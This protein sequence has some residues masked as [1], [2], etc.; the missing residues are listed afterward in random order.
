MRRVVIT[1]LGCVAPP[2]KSVPEFWSAMVAG[3]SSIGKY[4][5]A[6]PEPIGHVVLAP[7]LNFNVEDQFDSKRLVLLDRFSF[8]ALV[9]AREAVKDAGLV[10]TD[11]ERPRAA[12]VLGSGI[13][14]NTT[15]EEQYLRL[16]GAKTLRVHPLTI[17][18]LMLNA[19]TS[20]LTM[21]FGMMGPAYS[22]SSACASANH[23]IGQ[24]F[25]FVRS[26]IG[27]AHV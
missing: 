15:H 13:G 6:V 24:A 12:V 5:Q 25:W 9:A 14:G 3:R 11:A 7:V 19:A 4:P 18:K 10:L 2:G 27:R 8:F 20:Q 1:G 22:I 23:A 21:E 26:E 17:P 16:I